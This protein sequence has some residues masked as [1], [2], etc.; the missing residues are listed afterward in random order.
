M[1]QND[2]EADAISRERRAEYGAAIG[3]FADR[4]LCSET[5]ADKAVQLAKQKGRIKG[6]AALYRNHK[7]VENREAAA[8][9]KGATATKAANSTQ[10]KLGT[11]AVAH[12]TDTTSHTASMSG[13][14]NG[15]E[16]NER[17]GPTDTSAE[18]SEEP[19]DPECLVRRRTYL[20]EEFSRK[21]DEAGVVP[22]PSQ[23]QSDLGV[24]LF[25]VIYD[26]PS[27]QPRMFE[28]VETDANYRLFLDTIIKRYAEMQTRKIAE[29]A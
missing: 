27:G 26:Q 23:N 25:L 4:S 17:C 20:V 7:E 21:L 16:A 12:S 9:K 8:S 24:G 5:D 15:A 13:D 29:A 3:W 22:Y 28:I 19:A 2:P 11:S 10:A 1:I 18:A 6:I 14:S